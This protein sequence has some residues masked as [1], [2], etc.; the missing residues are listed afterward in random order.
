[1]DNKERENIQNFSDMVNATRGLVKPWII[2]CAILAAALVLTNAIWGFVHWKQTEYAYM[3]PEEY[4][5]EQLYDE[6]SQTQSYS[7][8]VTNGD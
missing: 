3:T 2:L 1:M 5:Q 4:T 7:S 8:G 6:H